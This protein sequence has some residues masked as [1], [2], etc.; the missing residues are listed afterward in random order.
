MSL[1]PPPPPAIV[2]MAAGTTLLAGLGHATVLPDLDFETY[3]EAG[4]IWN[5]AACCW[6]KLPGARFYGLDA[7]GTAVYATHPS[8]EILSLAYNLKDGRGRRHWKPG[9]PPPTDLFDHIA[10]GRLLEA[11]NA[12]FEHWVWQHVAVPKLGWPPLP[13]AQLRCSMAKARAH[14]LPGKLEALG[15]AMRL[16]IQKDKEGKRLLTKFSMPRDPTKKDPRRRINPLGDPEGPALYSYNGTDIDSEAEA[17]ARIPDL[18]PD[19]LEYWLNDQITNYRGCAIDSPTV[20]DCIAVI[21]ALAEKYNT[22]LHTIT[23]GQVER[24]S[25]RERLKGWLAGRGV[26]MP[27]MDEAAIDAALADARLVGLERE[28]LEILSKVGSASVKKLYMMRNQLSPW[29]RLHDLFNYHVARTGRDGGKDV[30]AQNLPRTG[31]DVFKCGSCGQFHGAHRFTCPWCAT[32]HPPDI[33]KMEWGIA[34][35][36]DAILILAT[37]DVGLVE[38]YFGDAQ[39]LV[40]GMLRM[41]FIAGPGHDLIASDYSAIEAVVTACLAGEDWRIKVFQSGEDI[42]YHSAAKQTGLTYQFYMD[43]KKANKKHHPHRQPFGKVRELSLGYGGWI[44]AMIQFGAD[45][46]FTEDEMKQAILGWRADSPNIVELWGGQWRGMP[47]HDDYHAEFYGLEGCAIQAVLNPGTEYTYCAKHELAR[48]IAFK[49]H[50]DALYCILPDGKA[51]TYHEPRLRRGKS[52]PHPDCYILS[53]MTWNTNPNKGALGWVRID[54]YGGMLCENVVQATARQI[55]RDAVNR[56]MRV[57]YMVVLRV[58]DEIVAEILKTFGS[59]EEFEAI[60]NAHKEW[61][62]AW[63]IKAKGGWRGLRFRKD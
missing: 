44:G 16:P 6:D 5:D 34:C 52:G 57:G 29:G 13:L 49:M 22:R 46:F 59:V 25:Q 26:F 45:E 38:N 1:P 51:I 4:H 9:D 31:P 17:S 35:A 20:A 41:M 55:L 39:T 11:H 33:K 56:L 62:A 8:T 61:A 58:H 23:G 28:S 7:C 27:A 50:G 47:W 30:Q 3:S 24:A 14:A 53:Y 32:V 36:D 42:Y 21:E 15:T 63:P 48:P 40:I 12:G 43:Y 2:D 18:D 60:M 37:R 19:E 54:T 10:A